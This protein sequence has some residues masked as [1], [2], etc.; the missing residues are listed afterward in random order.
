MRCQTTGYRERSWS[1]RLLTAL[2]LL[3]L[4]G[5]LQA[6][7]GG[8]PDLEGRFG[9][10]VSVR[11][12]PGQRCTATKIGVRHFLT[13][14]HCVI[15]IPSGALAG[16][17]QPGGQVLVSNWPEPSGAAAYQTLTVTQTHLPA[18]FAAALE[19]LHAYQEGRIAD[20]RARYSGE[21]LERRIRRVYADSHIMARFPDLAI[22]EVDGE[23]PSIPVAPVD[24]NPLAS[25]AEVVLVGYGCERVAD[26]AAGRL[27]SGPVRR[28][29][30]LS[31]VIRVDAVNFYTF[32]GDLQAGT[33]TTC[34]GDSG[35]P[36][37]KDGRVVGVHGTVYGLSRRDSAR[38]NMSV[39]LHSL[40]DWDAWPL[41]GGAPARPKVSR[42]GA[43]PE[44]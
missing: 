38:S 6:L 44:R 16:A 30:G 12:D 36:V 10:V 37:L 8:Q 25:G 23:T 20:F 41:A 33:P 39:N 13:A 2:V 11:T 29:W 14:A 9:S 1:L 5:Q 3:G 26:L 43:G 21:D 17:F 27:G 28:I 22:V 19:R 15:D 35:G 40:A 4:S 24:L 7:I 42:S 18:S 31:R 34:P 32:A